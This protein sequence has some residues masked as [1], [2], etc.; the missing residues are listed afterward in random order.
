MW[1]A[2]DLARASVRRQGAGLSAA[3]VADKVAEAAQRER[4]SSAQLDSPVADSGPY[5]MDSED[6]A[7]Q[8]AARHAEWRRVAALVGA[9]GW[10]AYAPEQDVQGNLWARERDERRTGVIARHAAWQQERRD[11]QDELRTKV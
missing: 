2:E 5:A 10:S 6:L 1:G 8:W 3:Q 9:C 11:A 7:E 4:E